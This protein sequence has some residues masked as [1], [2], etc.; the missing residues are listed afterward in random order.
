MSRNPD[1]IEVSS[2]R[3]RAFFCTALLDMVECPALQ[4]PVNRLNCN[5]FAMVTTPAI[6]PIGSQGQRSERRT[7]DIDIAL[8]AMERS[9][10]IDHIVLLAAND[11]T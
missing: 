2:R 8:D 7:V 5:G 1:R 6:T 9:P 10:R 11:D 3:L 4:P